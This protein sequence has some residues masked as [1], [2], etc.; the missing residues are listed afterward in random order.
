[1][2]E[3]LSLFCLDNDLALRP[4]TANAE[5]LSYSFCHSSTTVADLESID[6]VTKKLRLSIDGFNVNK[7][8]AEDVM[9]SF[10]QR[11]ANLGH[12]E[13]LDVNFGGYHR[14]VPDRVVEALIRAVKANS[15]LLNLCLRG[16]VGVSGWEPH[17]AARLDGL[18]DYKAPRVLRIE[19]SNDSDPGF[20]HLRKCLS[21]KIDIIVTNL[22]DG[23]HTDGSLMDELYRLNR[24]YMGSNDLLAS[25]PLI[26][27]S[28]V[29]AAFKRFPTICSLDVRSH[30]CVVGPCLICR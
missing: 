22:Y 14:V 7:L 29:E 4:L 1:M 13:E 26:R 28:Q 30:R 9:L 25:P 18:R 11:V 10:W 3:K 27:S 24:F 12:F 8:F 19:L 16:G 2:V 5:S 15:E 17:V 6:I 21:H 23:V 20:I